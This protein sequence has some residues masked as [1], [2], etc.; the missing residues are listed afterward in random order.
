ML[1][2]RHKRLAITDK[3]RKRERFYDNVSERAHAKLTIHGR[4]TQNIDIVWSSIFDVFNRK[5]VDNDMTAG[6]RAAS[7]IYRKR[8]FTW[9]DWWHA[10]GPNANIWLLSSTIVDF[11]LLA[12]VF[13][14]HGRR[15][16]TW[17]RGE[18]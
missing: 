1:Y 10:N 17:S 18:L 7:P 14:A 15:E 5:C 12:P 2:K 9:A 3:K 16:D 4:W 11:P 8:P 6:G 13:T